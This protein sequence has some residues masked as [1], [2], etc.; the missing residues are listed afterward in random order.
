MISTAEKTRITRD[1]GKIKCILDD[2]YP[3]KDNL[4]P[5]VEIYNEFFEDSSIAEGM[6]EYWKHQAD[7]ATDWRG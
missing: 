3:G 4:K 5:A 6:R 7:G 2:Y 1:I